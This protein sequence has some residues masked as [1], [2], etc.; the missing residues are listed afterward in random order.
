MLRAMKPKISLIIPFYNEALVALKTLN[1]VNAQSVNPEEVI[2]VDSSSTDNT[3]LIINNFISK[4]NLN[5]WK[6]VNTNYKTPSEA[7]NH[8]ISISKYEWCA[9]MDF[10][11]K[12]SKTWI[13]DQINFIKE[14]NILISYGRVDLMPT[15]IFDKFVVAQTYGLKSSSP[16]IP[17]SFINKKYFIKHGNFKP[18]RSLYDKYFIKKSL[19]L[20]SELVKINQK[21]SIQYMH[22]NYAKNYSELFIK[23]MNYSLQSFFFKSHF[24]PYIYFIIFYIFL[25][26]IYLNKLFIIPI[27]ILLF[28]AR[29]I[30]IPKIKNKKYFNNFNSI[31]ILRLFLI[32][33]FIDIVKLIGFKTSLILRLLNIKIRLDKFYK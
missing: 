14:N 6:I 1:L 8:G 28:L 16:V 15:N 20:K 2:F 10:D 25:F 19:E 9:F 23:T 30:I 22:I 26:F 7:K 21:I 33:T 12:F 3:S 31:D 18:F 13:N 27:I 5:N 11:L 17:S 29:G 4:N 24:I 32:G